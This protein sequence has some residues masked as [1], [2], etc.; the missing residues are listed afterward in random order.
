MFYYYASRTK[1]WTLLLNNNKADRTLILP[2][3]FHF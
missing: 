3:T 1:H 2:L